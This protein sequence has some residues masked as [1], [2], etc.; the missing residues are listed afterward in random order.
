MFSFELVGRE[1]E[2]CST[3]TVNKGFSM[4]FGF[5]FFFFFLFLGGG[6]PAYIYC[7][8]FS[9]Q[10]FCAKYES[11]RLKN[12]QCEDIIEALDIYAKHIAAFKVHH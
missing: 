10:S 3:H 7:C 12:K 4:V 11:Q 5:C 8:V 2:E 9:K 6:G 1:R